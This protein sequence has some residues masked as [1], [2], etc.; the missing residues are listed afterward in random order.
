M[1]L[2]EPTWWYADRPRTEAALLAPVSAL[3]GWT[4]R[5]RLTRG[6]PVRAALPVICVGNLVAGGSGKTPTTLMIED[7]LSELGHHPQFL[8][9]GYGGREAGPIVVD[10]ARHLAADVGD[11]ALLLAARART[12]VARRRDQGAALIARTA[13][14]G[15]VIVMDD[16]LQNPHLAKDLSLAVIDAARGIGNGRVIPAGPLRAPLAFQLGLVDAAI[17]NRGV[18][19]ASPAPLAAM[20]RDCGFTR[21]VLTVAVQPSGDLSWLQGARVL[22]FAGI[23]NPDRFFTLL[24]ALGATIESRR[25][26]ADH[27]PISTAAAGEILEAAQR[28]DLKLVTTEK[29]LARIG[30]GAGNGAIRD[31]AEHARTV[32]IRIEIGED[33][34]ARLK[35][36]IREAIARKSRVHQ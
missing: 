19:S 12:T 17:I 9:R 10:P 2:N 16:G 7:C 11:E 25:T 6:R 26:F 22:A 33:D 4:A 24:A 13:P 8:T 31:L 1:P 3:Y 34:R 36:L 23:A 21:D 15:S 32:P 35:T 14:A 5:M 30:A 29:D 28:A 20:L 18:S 27:A